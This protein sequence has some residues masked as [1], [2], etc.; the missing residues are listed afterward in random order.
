VRLARDLDVLGLR[1]VIVEQ[2]RHLEDG[3]EVL[4]KRMMLAV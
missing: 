2:E 4:A 1:W 3:L